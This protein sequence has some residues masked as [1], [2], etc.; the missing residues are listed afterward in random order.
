M[1]NLSHTSVA[2]G[3]ARCYGEGPIVRCDDIT[4]V[5]TRQSHNPREILTTPR[6]PVTYIE[7]GTAIDLASPDTTRR[8]SALVCRIAARLADQVVLPQAR[9]I[10][11]RLGVRPTG[12]KISRGHRRLGYCDWQG[13]IAL[14]SMLVLMPAELRRFVICHELAHLTEMNHGSAFH[15]ICDTYL[16]GRER[17]LLA[18]LRAFRFPLL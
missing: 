2:V 18:R 3:T 16:D 12:W 5:V 14:S 6:I 9:H 10:A 1:G 13:W 15:T 11:A 17:E 8:I 4:I 7:V